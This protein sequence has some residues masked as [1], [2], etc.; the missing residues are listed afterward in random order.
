MLAIF[1]KKSTKSLRRIKLDA[2]LYNDDNIEI[3]NDG[4][5]VKINLKKELHQHPTSVVD[6]IPP[7][8]KIICNILKCSYADLN[9][10]S[11]SDL[12]K[13]LFE[14]HFSNTI[15]SIKSAIK[16]NKQEDF[17][18]GKIKEYFNLSEEK[19]QEALEE[20]RKI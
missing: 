19:W 2:T 3:V 5:E 7:H 17:I 9:A 8:I 13:E 1:A 20:A 16:F 12:K 14:K 4:E 18:N 11:M 10:K 6:D 15:N